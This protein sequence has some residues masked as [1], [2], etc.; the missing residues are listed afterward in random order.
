VTNFTPAQLRRLPAGG[1]Y[2]ELR[3]SLFWLTHV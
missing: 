2:T 1:K 3:N